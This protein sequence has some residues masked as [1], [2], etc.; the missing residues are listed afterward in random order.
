M[1]VCNRL[2]DII[3]KSQKSS[4]I[5]CRKSAENL[6]ENAVKRRYYD[7]VELIKFVDPLSYKHKNLY[8]LSALIQQDSVGSIPVLFITASAVQTYIA[9]QLVE[10]ACSAFFNVL[11]YKE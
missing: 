4:L 10:F 5:I 8:R 6:P 11:L 7:T 9:T 1:D 2:S 3:S